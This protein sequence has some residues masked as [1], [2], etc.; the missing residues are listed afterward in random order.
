MANETGDMK[1][2]GYF[3]RLIDLVETDSL[4]EPSNAA[5]SVANLETKLTAAIAAVERIAVKTAPSKAAINARQDLSAEVRAL[6]RGSR[7]LL[8]ASGASAQ[9]IADADTYADKVLGL[10]KSEKQSD[11]PA[12]PDDEGSGNHSASQQSY[13]AVLGNFRSYIEI[14][15]SEPLYAPNEEKYQT[16]ALGSKADALEAAN[17]A[18]SATFVPLDSARAMRD[19]L[20]YTNK[21]SLC[22]LAA[23]VKAYVKAVHGAE[24]QFFKTVNALSFKRSYR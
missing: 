17:D 16:A 12:M 11:D 5:L 6:V 18:V 23:M 19:Q 3:R 7:N 14:L 24:S 10:R 1:I 21:D 9:T 20:L 2:I 22:D 13:E 4:Y 15:D 8:K